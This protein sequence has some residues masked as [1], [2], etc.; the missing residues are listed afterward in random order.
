VVLKYEFW[1]RIAHI[2]RNV[3]IQIHISL[4]AGSVSR[5]LIRK[6]KL[7]IN[8]KTSVTLGFVCDICL[9]LLKYNL[10]A[11]INNL[12]SSSPHV[13]TKREWKTLVKRALSQSETALWNQRL[14]IDRD[15]TFFRILH[16]GITPFIVYQ[17]Y[18]QGSL[19]IE[20]PGTTDRPIDKRCPS[21]PD[22][23]HVQ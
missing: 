16:L 21:S 10:H 13:P 23:G 19:L 1:K 3:N 18:N 15:F 17:V 22:Y 6:L 2:Y 4:P 8:N 7:F 14:A 12:L 9:I 5:E 11:I 20:S